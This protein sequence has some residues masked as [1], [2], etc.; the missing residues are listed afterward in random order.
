M[1][2]SA[3]S[4]YFKRVNRKTLSK[5][6]NEIRIGYA[7]KKLKEGDLTITQICYESGYN[8]LSNFNKQFK[9]ITGKTPSEYISLSSKLT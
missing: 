8:S 7:C 5:Y 1:N 6:I 9:N 4:R 3:F 2:P